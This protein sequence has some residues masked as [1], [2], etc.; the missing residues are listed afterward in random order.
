[1][2][3]S[4]R[5]ADLD[6]VQDFKYFGCYIST[7]SDIEREISTMNRVCSSSFQCN[8]VRNIWKSS[9]LQTKIKLKIYRS[10]VRSAIL[11]A[12]EIWRTNKKL[13]SRFKGV[14]WRECVYDEYSG[15]AGNN[16][17]PTGKSVDER[18]S[19]TLSKR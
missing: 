2:K 6:Y 8:K 1:M 16:V 7:D 13:E 3:T 15:S 9:L 19:T 10:N 14:M 17:S 11:Y 18:A 12:M 5:G 4:I